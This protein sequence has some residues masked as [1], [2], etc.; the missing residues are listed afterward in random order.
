[1][2]DY[3]HPQDAAEIERAKLAIAVEQFLGGSISEDVFLAE[4]FTR[5]FRGQALRSEFR[6]WDDLRIENARAKLPQAR[7]EKARDGLDR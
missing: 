7:M 3:Q 4:L 6:Y 5:G 2:R 1:M